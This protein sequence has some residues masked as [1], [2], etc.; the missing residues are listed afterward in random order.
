MLPIPV[1]ALQ[2]I[3][4]LKESYAQQIIKDFLPQALKLFR[5]HHS[6][7][8]IG[9]F[10]HAMFK[11]FAYYPQCRKDILEPFATFTE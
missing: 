5:E 3:A 1:E 9:P 11:R 7:Q 10:L 4:K 6:E 8:S 2:Q